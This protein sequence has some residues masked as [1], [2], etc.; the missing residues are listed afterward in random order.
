M[1]RHRL[2]PVVLLRNGAVVHDQTVQNSQEGQQ[3]RATI[4]L[5]IPEDGWLAA[6]LAS[7]ARD[8]FF[9]PLF[10]HTS[11]IYVRC[12]V[13]NR[14]TPDAA[15]SFVRGLDGAL[16]WVAT[17]GRFRAEKQQREVAGLFREARDVYLRWAG[18]ES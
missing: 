4:G 9:Q 17:Q 3:G 10:A 13:P 14:T 18:G 2:I 11:P 12:G 15:A 16:E 5:D 8:S 7:N 6:R 1:L